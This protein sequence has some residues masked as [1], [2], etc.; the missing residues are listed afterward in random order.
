MTT[1]TTD[2]KVEPATTLPP[3]EAKKDVV[4]KGYPT[5]DEVRMAASILGR[6]GGRVSSTK[7]T[8]AVQRNGQ[9]GGFATAG[10]KRKKLAFGRRET[11]ATRLEDLKH[12]LGI[13]ERK[14]R[15]GVVGN[16]GGEL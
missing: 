2:F 14:G 10:R 5:P 16:S 12:I 7:K 13:A 8:L 4:L 6:M 15:K 1:E 9:L 3:V 11:K